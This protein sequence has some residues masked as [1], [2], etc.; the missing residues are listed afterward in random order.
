[1][2]IGHVA[3]VVD[4]ANGQFGS[5]IQVAKNVARTILEAR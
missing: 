5:E 3:K 2:K 1:M 4:L